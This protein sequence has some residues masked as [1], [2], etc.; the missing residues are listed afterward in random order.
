MRID[1]FKSPLF[2]FLCLLPLSA[3]AFSDAGSLYVGVVGGGTVGHNICNDNNLNCDNVSSSAGIV[4]GVDVNNWSVHSTLSW[5]GK[6]DAAYPEQNSQVT[7][8]LWSGTLEAKYQYPVFIDYTAYFGAGIASVYTDKST[9]GGTTSNWSYAPLVSV[10]LEYEYDYNLS[11]FAEY[12]Y[13]DFDDEELG[14]SNFNQLYIGVKYY[15]W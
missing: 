8:E 3:N 5:L 6:F 1:K 12:R 14:K 7:A 13:M 4:L 10:G 15:P 11:Y 2:A 9:A